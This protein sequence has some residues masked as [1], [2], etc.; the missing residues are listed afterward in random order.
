MARRKADLPSRD[1]S[2]TKAVEWWRFVGD[3]ES[4]QRAEE[5]ECLRFQNADGAW[6]ADVKA[7]RS[8]LVPGMDGYNA[9][10][11]PI[12]ARPMISIASLDQPFALASAQQ[13]GAK[14]SGQI[15]ALTEDASDD[16]ATVLQGLNRAVDRESHAD[17]IRTWSY[18]R[19]WWTGRG[20][21][22]IDKDY[23][24]TGGHPFDQ[25]LVMRRILDQA[26]VR[27]DPH[28]QEPDWSDG[29]RAMVGV[30]MSWQAYKEKYP[31]S[32]VASFDEKTLTL[33]SEQDDLAGW[34]QGTSDDTR[35]VTVAEDWRVAV[36]RRKYVLLDNND[37]SPEDNIPEGRTALTGEGARFK[38]EEERAVFFRVINCCEVLEDEQEWDGAYIPIIPVI[39]RELQPVDG[40]RQWIGPVSNTKGAVRLVNVSA[41]GAVE[42]AA[43]EPKAPWMAEPEAIEGFEHEYQQSNI[44][45]IPVLHHNALSKDGARKL[46]RPERVQVDVSRLGPNL[47]LLTLGKEFVNT[48][49]AVHDPSL[50]KQT[51]A[52]RSGRAIQALQD[53]SIESTSLGI[54]NL[55]QI[56]VMYEMK[57]KL[58]LFPRVYDR[59]ERLARI[60]D[61]Q[62]KSSPV[63]LNAPFTPGAKPQALP[64]TI[65]ET[66]TVQMPAQTQQM[67]N[68][69]KHPAKYYDLNKGRYGVE[70]TIGKSYA[71]KRQEGAAELGQ[72]LAS[73]PALFTI[74][75]PEYLKYRG[76]QWAE[77]AAAILEKNR[78]HM[79]PW[80][81]TNQEAPNAQQMQQIMSENQHLKGM[82]EQ[83]GKA[84][85]TKQI[86]QQGK[87]EIT[88]IQEGAESERA[89]KDREAKLAV[90]AL[91]GKFETMQNAMQLLADEIAR[92]GSQQHD[93]GQAHLDRTH[94]AATASAQAAHEQELAQQQ[95]VHDAALAEQG[96]AQNLEAIAAEPP[97]PN[98]SGQ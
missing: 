90:A 85:E 41:S 79:M 82:L 98:G 1:T 14:V 18:E 25:K 33:L 73:D 75:G 38:F 57:V 11:G 19:A 31:E 83:A 48:G 81:A 50:G 55:A 36:T 12:P 47:T 37:V 15:H 87:K 6:P 21:Y 95:A 65:D 2:V 28:A 77:E 92:I 68:D 53:Q 10:I 45:N 29:R 96:H 39:W 27:L 78:D 5:Q 26:A 91:Q 35:T 76:E 40:K 89:D 8:A 84:I 66:G 4:E 63:M 62:N 17:R 42:M 22:R 94:D 7:N 71:D 9:K 86:E 43:L 49:T 24:P 54:D 97:S 34:V 52:F 16:T 30:S 70:V 80:L 60:L 88:L 59:P 44:R 58:D 46:D 23:D 64:Y 56:S 32:R 13:R 67:V 61:E 3:V 72:F 93:A 51:P 20:A 69:P 74:L